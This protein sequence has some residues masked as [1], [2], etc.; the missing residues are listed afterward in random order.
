MFILFPTNVHPIKSIHEQLE[1]MLAQSRQLAG[2]PT[3]GQSIV[4][5]S[6]GTMTQAT[7][8]SLRVC[9][10]NTEHYCISSPVSFKY[11]LKF[12][13]FFHLIIENKK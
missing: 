5:A 12:F 3:M 2:M 11:L 7:S 10:E 6:V 9:L 4:Q 8:I 1:A 13:L